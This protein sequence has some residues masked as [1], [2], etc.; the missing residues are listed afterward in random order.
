MRAQSTALSSPIVI[1]KARDLAQC[2]DNV[3]FVASEGCFH[4]FNEWQNLI[5]RTLS[6]EANEVDAGICTTWRSDTLMQWSG[7]YWPQDVF[8]ADETALFF[9]LQPD[10]T[11]T[12]KGD[13]CSCGRRRKGRA[14]VLVAKNMTGTQEVPFVIG[15]APKLWCFK[16]NRHSQQSTPDT[17]RPRM[18][19]DLF[20]KRLLKF[21]R[22]R[23]LD[24][25]RVVLVVDN[26]LT[27]KFDVENRQQV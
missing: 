13:S 25:R 10:K 4:R 6:G 12:H 19:G 26:C 1:A 8:S 27:N 2:L 20:K 11:I 5:F 24:G 22:Q 18:T 7:S 9:K 3:Y 17:R 21:D 14:T 16:N 15:K 23:E